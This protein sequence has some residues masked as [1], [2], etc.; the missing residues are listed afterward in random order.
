TEELAAW[1]RSVRGATDVVVSTKRPVPLAQYVNVGRKLF[2]LYRAG[3][4][5]PDPALVNA[6][7]RRSAERKKR[8]SDRERRAIIDKL[9]ERR[10]LP[11]IEFIFSRKGCDK[12]V[13]AL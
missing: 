6:L 5:D 11:A 1:M 8:V 12:A 4:L 13:E 7:G 2:P 9:G 3:T 10:M